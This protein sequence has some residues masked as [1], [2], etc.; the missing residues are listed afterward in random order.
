[1]LLTSKFDGCIGMKP[2]TRESKDN[3]FLSKLFEAEMI[4]HM[5]YSIYVNN[6]DQKSFIK[7]GSMDTSAFGE[8]IT[9]ISTVDASNW[10]LN[11]SDISMKEVDIQQRTNNY[12]YIEPSLPYFYV[13]ESIWQLFSIQIEVMYPD[14]KC[15]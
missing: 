8:N 9:I 5:V 15:N 6:D 14:V 7:F 13:P 2:I 12:L 10:A 3:N 4:D 11:V 1:M